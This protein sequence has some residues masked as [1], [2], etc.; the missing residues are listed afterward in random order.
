MKL[1]TRTAKPSTTPKYYPADGTRGK[2]FIAL[3][4]DM[5]DPTKEINGYNRVV[6]FGNVAD[7]INSAVEKGLKKL[8]VV[9]A[10]IRDN[11]FDGVIGTIKQTDL[12]CHEVK[13]GKKSYKDEFVTE[14][15]GA[16]DAP[17]F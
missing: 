14:A 17:P 3:P 2:S 11:S 7:A 5:V 10:S 8:N 12:V 9:W 15:A 13:I 6:A 1:I 16:G 4:A